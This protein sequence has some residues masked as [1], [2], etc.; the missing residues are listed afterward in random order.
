MFLIPRHSS[1]NRRFIPF[2]FFDKNIIVSDSCTALP[3]A[4]MYHFGVISSSMHMTW[5]K[6]IC[7]RIKSDF[8]YSNVLVYNNFPWPEDITDKKKSTIENAVH[9]VLEA[10]AGFPD[11]SLADL[12]DPLTMPSK[13]V[14]AHQELDK[15]VDLAYRPQPFVSE[16]KRIEFLFDLYERYIGSSLPGIETETK[17]VKSKTKS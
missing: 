8:R 4:S 9:K 15:A 2:G 10:R 16:T 6:Y 17:K 5:V 11:S 7:G 1:E 14:K 3:N 13:L 12:Y